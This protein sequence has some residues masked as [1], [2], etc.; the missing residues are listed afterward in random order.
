MIFHD[1]SNYWKLPTSHIVFKKIL[2][3]AYFK[4][5]RD[6][7]THFFPLKNYLFKCIIVIPNNFNSSFK[8][9]QIF[10]P[11]IQVFFFFKIAIFSSH[12]NFLSFKNNDFF[13]WSSLTR[14]KVAFYATLLANNS[15][16]KFPNFSSNFSYITISKPSKPLQYPPTHFFLPSHP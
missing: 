3:L 15:L 9:V 10:S 6:I 5:G 4:I 13:I 2:I 8:I 7:P 12:L 1:L 11:V 14:M 16:K